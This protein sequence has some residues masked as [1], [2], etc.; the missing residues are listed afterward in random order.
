MKMIRI[1]RGGTAKSAVY[2][3]AAATYGVCAADEIA[4]VIGSTVVNRM[5]KATTMRALKKLAATVARAK[6]AAAPGVGNLALYAL[7]MTTVGPQSPSKFT[8]SVVA[9]AT[10][11]VETN[12]GI[13]V[14]NTFYAS[15]DRSAEVL[16]SVEAALN[17][18]KYNIERKA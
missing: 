3:A 14:G 4:L 12:I 11:P 7:T 2:S 13:L 8:R 6:K 15:L 10:A 18:M 16:R 1:K 5:T 9:G 17:A